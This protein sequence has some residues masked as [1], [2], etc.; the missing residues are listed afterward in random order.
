MLFLSLALPFNTHSNRLRESSNSEHNR[1]QTAPKSKW[2]WPVDQPLP[3]LVEHT[4]R[5]EANQ[6]TYSPRR[7]SHCQE[8]RG[9][10]QNLPRSDVSL[11]PHRA[12]QASKLIW[13]TTM[14]SR[15]HTEGLVPVRIMPSGSRQSEYMPCLTGSTPECG[16]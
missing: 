11:V 8:K 15:K 7:G 13:P 10:Q 1:D 6:M 2:S 9:V 16:L 5:N 3:N 12:G 4:N 14:L